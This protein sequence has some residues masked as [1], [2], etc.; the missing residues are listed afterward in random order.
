M[1]DATGGCS[2]QNFTDDV[3]SNFVNVED[4]TSLFKTV[5]SLAAGGTFAKTYGG[6]TALG[7]ATQAMAESESG[8]V[9][10]G[11]GA[12]T[13]TQAAVTAGAT[14]AINGV[15]IKGT[16]DSG[17]LISSVLRTAVNRAA[18]S[19]CGCKQ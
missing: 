15:L 18:S 3:V 17:V 9:M 19:S 11:L 5:G 2:N 16:Y 6:L 1:V 12:R 7:A 14:W 4:S 10:T 8:I 13:F